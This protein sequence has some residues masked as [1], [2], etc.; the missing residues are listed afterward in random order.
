M[1]NIAEKQSYDPELKVQLLLDALAALGEKPV[2]EGSLIA[3]LCSLLII[4]FGDTIQKLGST[5]VSKQEDRPSASLS[6]Q[7]SFDRLR[8]WSDNYGICAGEQD[9]SF[10]K[11]RHLRRTTTEILTSISDTVLESMFLFSFMAP[12]VCLVFI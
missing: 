11:S 12:Q 6:L 7:R 9:T 8:L 1:E 4:V 5:K 10:S 2:E 3:R